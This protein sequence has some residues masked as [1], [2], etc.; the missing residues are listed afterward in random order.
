MASFL[1]YVITSVSTELGGEC[2]CGAT[3]SSLQSQ[4]DCYLGQALLVLYFAPKT[5]LAHISR[6]LTLLCE[7]TIL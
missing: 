3:A 2:F 4:N 7:D 6:V 1:V 5:Q